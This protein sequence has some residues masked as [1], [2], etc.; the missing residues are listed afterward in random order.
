MQGEFKTMNEW[1]KYFIVTCTSKH[2]LILHRYKK[3]IK[4]NLN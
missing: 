1:E 3:E 2:I 4:F